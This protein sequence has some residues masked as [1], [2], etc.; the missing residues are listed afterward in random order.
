MRN[1]QSCASCTLIDLHRTSFWLCVSLNVPYQSY[2][3]NL[4]SSTKYSQMA[5]PFWHQ[6]F[7]RSRAT[8][9]F[10]S[11]T[12]FTGHKYYLTNIPAQ[13]FVAYFCTFLKSTQIVFQRLVLNYIVST[14]IY[15]RNWQ[16]QPPAVPLPWFWRRSQRQSELNPHFGI[17]LAGVRLYCYLLQ[18]SWPSSWTIVTVILTPRYLVLLLNYKSDK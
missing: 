13:N 1:C 8:Y 10:R 14:C 11:K 2:I 9:L 3:W 6:T 18:K 12:T 5:H 17:S 16:W 4:S 7:N 15:L